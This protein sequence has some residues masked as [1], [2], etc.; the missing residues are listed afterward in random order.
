MVIFHQG[1]LNAG[2][3]EPDFKIWVKTRYFKVYKNG[4]SKTNYKLG[5]CGR[6]R[7]EKVKNERIKKEDSIVRSSTGYSTIG[8]FPLSIGH[9]QS[10]NR[11]HST[12]QSSTFS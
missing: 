4:K 7:N 6:K 9:V 8:Y 11:V 10:I 12:N 5:K 2:T 3:I 1:T